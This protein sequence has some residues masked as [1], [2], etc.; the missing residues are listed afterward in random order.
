MKNIL[1]NFFL[2]VFTIGYAQVGINTTTP[3]NAAVLHLESLNSAG[4]Y[5]GFMP[6]VVNQSQRDAIDLILTP[7]DDGLMIYLVEGTTRCIQMYNAN[8][9][10]WEDMYCMPVPAPPSII[11]YQDFEVTPNTP[12]LTYAATG[13]SNSTGSGV[14]PSTNMFSE[15]TRGYKS[16][17][18]D[19]SVNFDGVDTSAFT[20]NNLSFDLASFSGT[21]GN[22]ADGADQIEVLIS[23]DNATWSSEVTV[24]GNSNAR[25]SFSGSAVASAAYDGNN[26]PVAY[27]APSGGTLTGPNAYSKVTLSG[28]P[29][30]PTLYI[31]IRMYNNNSNEIWVIDNVILNLM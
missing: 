30:V 6:P 16:S 19:N 29:S 26:T 12:E 27:T 13:G 31:Q 8:L 5:G 15:G 10:Q 11:Y 28:L 21:S 20:T 7:T 9:T 14:S 1:L 23:T 22:G 4:T 24:N 2:I 25:W 18:G 3:S 17:N